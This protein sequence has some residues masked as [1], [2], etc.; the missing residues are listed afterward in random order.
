M[1]N[2][3]KILIVD[4]NPVIVELLKKKL[5]SVG[6]E[7]AEAFDGEE[8]LVKAEEFQPGLIFLDIVMPKLDGF[9]VCRRLKADKK[10]K[11]I[12]V[13]MLTSKNEATDT[14]T[15]LEA[16]AD[17]YI[18]KPFEFMEIVARAKSILAKK[19][20]VEEHAEEKK[21]EALEHVTDEIAHEIR[22]PLVS[23]GGFARRVIKKLPDDSREKKYM[24]IILQ[25]VEVLE[26]M[27]EH[28][29]GLKDAD[30][31]Y[32]EPCDINE[33][34]LDTLH[35]HDEVLKEKNIKV[36]TNLLEDPI[37]LHVDRSN[38]EKT[39]FNII[40]NAS[41]SIQN[42]AGLIEIA[43]ARENEKNFEIKITD[44]GRGIPRD[45]VKNIFNPFF[46]SK[47][48]G[49]GLGLT[50]ADRTVKSHKGAIH[51]ESKEGKG[52]TIKIRLPI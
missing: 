19:K 10:T 49:P 46:S 27:V 6:Y 50:F 2:K 29:V 11:H 45:K 18:A 13:I 39:I 12:S 22:N 36:K 26:K 42:N 44:S 35:L 40:S 32:V 30:L 43:T 20:E 34:I 23:I 7:T 28:L 15:G 4:D 1:N 5:G 14:V 25:N 51:V 37:L 9:E 31:S 52:T 24:D 17:D 3:D 47:I 41:E 16:G 8:C 48:Y 38:I 33:I 21:V